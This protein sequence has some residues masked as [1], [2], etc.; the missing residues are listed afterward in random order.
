MLD[1]DQFR[2][3][4]H[5]IT[6]R[7]LQIQPPREKAPPPL[8]N[9]VLQD[10]LDYNLK[11][12]AAL[13]DPGR[14]EEARRML[15]KRNA[16]LRA[17]DRNSGVFEWLER[18]QEAE[19]IRKDFPALAAFLEK[20]AAS[21]KNDDHCK[22]KRSQSPSDQ[23]PWQTED[24]SWNSDQETGYFSQDIQPLHWKDRSGASRY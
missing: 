14:I 16:V 23:H 15:K 6:S 8:Q 22:R 24:T 11:V 2:A 10:Q 17:A 13:E 21:T 18:T 4:S 9:K 19:A 20:D 12:L 1:D 5:C 3:L 7:I